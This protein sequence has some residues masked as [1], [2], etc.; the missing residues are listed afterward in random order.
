MFEKSKTWVLAEHPE[1]LPDDKTFRLEER[2]L[3]VLEAGQVLGKSRWLS[4]DPYMRGRISKQA[5]YAGGVAIGEHMHGGAVA[6]VIESR[7]PDWQ[8][9]DLFETISFGWQE[10]A[11]VSGDGLTRVDPSLDAPEHAW[12][13][14]LGMPGLT[15][16]IALDTIGHVKEGDTVL[17]SAASGAVGQVVGQI[18]KIRGARAVAVAS[19]QD[20]LNWCREIGFDA[21][22]NYREEENLVRAVAEAC[23]N[24]IDVFFDNTAGPI[25]D[26]AMQ[27]LAMNARVVICGTVSLAGTFEKPDMGER[28]LRKILVA[29]ARV[30]G[31]LIFDHLDKYDAARRQLAEWASQG[32]LTFKTD[33]LDGI[34]Q[35]P[36]AF[37][38]ILTSQNFGKQVV[39][40]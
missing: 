28:F 26:A 27:N 7:H 3:P 4:V 9:G 33:I 25:H 6:E 12:L 29:R 34:E 8:P 14:Y 31:F 17:V 35:M 37:Q 30:E 39:K 1:G 21:G 40:V 10:Y 20:K 23:P 22:I 2:V 16:L 19:S 36:T 38:N 32:S 13:S 5:N 18:A 15:A 11:A 24:G